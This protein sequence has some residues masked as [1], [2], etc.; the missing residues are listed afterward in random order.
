MRY[1][2]SMENLL[3]RDNYLQLCFTIPVSTSS[4][5][6]ISYHLS[7]AKLLSQKEESFLVEESPIQ[8][9]LYYILCLLLY[10]SSTQKLTDFMWMS[11]NRTANNKSQLLPLVCGVMATLHPLESSRKTIFIWQSPSW[12]KDFQHLCWP[13]LSHNQPLR[14]FDQLYS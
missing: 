1:S 11:F 6:I 5:Y 12:F 2:I 4:L 9:L 10:L 3:F 8:F 13:L 7:D 14:I